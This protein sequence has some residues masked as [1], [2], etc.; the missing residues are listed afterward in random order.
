MVLDEEELDRD[1]LLY[2][3]HDLRRHHQ[4]RAVAHQRPYGTLGRR[5]FH[6][7][8]GRNLVPH[9]GVA[10]FEVVLVVR[11]R[12]PQFVQVTGERAGRVDDDVRLVGDGVQRAEYLRLRGPDIR[13]V[14]LV[15]GVDALFP[16]FLVLGVLAGVPVRDP[17]VVERQCLRQLLQGAAG[18]RD[19]RGGG[20]L[21]AVVR[22]DVE[23]QEADVRRC[24]QGVGG[25]REVRVAGA[26]AYHQVG[27]AR[28][29]VRC[30][31]ARVADAADVL[32]VVVA[33]GALAGL[34]GGD[35]DTGRRG[36]LRQ[37]LLRAA[38]VDSAA[39]DDQGAAGGTDRPYRFG[40]FVGVGGRAAYVPHAVGEEL[41]RPVVRLG[42]N[43][44]RE[45][46]SYGACLDRVGED[47]HR[48][49]RRRD[50]RLGARD[51]VEVPRHRAQTVVDRHVTGV[52]DFEL[53]EDRVRRA[54][55][56]GVA[57]EEQDGEVVDRGERGTGD[58]VGRAGADRGRHSVRGETVGLPRV[59]DCRVHHGLFVAALVERHVVA[60]LD[61]R[62]AEP[63]DVPVAEDAP[64]GLDQAAADAVPLGVLGGQ[65][66]YERLRDREPRRRGRGGRGHR[67]PPVLCTWAE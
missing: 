33:Q 15:G 6:T 38:V 65:E 67:C 52:R 31:R 25:S 57:G 26:D 51:T 42:L 48:L 19:Q 20:Q 62:L 40:Q 24:E 16:A 12:A 56:E 41:V 44:L 47:P 4:V 58:E 45:S 30:R 63:G 36:E 37:R 29:F 14:G 39:R 43:V 53:L 7:D 49:Q 23:V 34:G 64:G 9:A 55:R 11:P 3:R 10:V 50:Q 8:R 46:E 59:T 13:L 54:G 35:G 60:V 2:G 27:Q 1:P 18:V 61:E 32:G 66:A 5:Q 17:V 21:V 22:G 28:E